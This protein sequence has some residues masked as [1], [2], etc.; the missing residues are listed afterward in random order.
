MF[1]LKT[2]ALF[3]NGNHIK[4]YLFKIKL[5][6]L[7]IVLNGLPAFIEFGC[8][9]SFFWTSKSCTASILYFKKYRHII[10]SCD[11]IN[12]TKSTK[13]EISIENLV[14][15]FLEIFNSRKLSYISWL[16]WACHSDMNYNPSPCVNTSGTPF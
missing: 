10:L 8:N 15:M 2:W 3:G 4:T 12:L 11:D 5:I 14:V 9:N 13:F 6:F 7:T 1:Q 16:F